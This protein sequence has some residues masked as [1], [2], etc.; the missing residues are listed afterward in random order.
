MARQEPRRGRVEAATEGLPVRVFGVA[1]TIA[2]CFRRRRSI[3]L[4]VALQGLQEALRRHKAT[5]ADAEI[6]R[7]FREGKGGV[8]TVLRPCLEVLTANA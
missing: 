6:V 2:D 1:K 4:S 5:P 8:A 7:H 3:D